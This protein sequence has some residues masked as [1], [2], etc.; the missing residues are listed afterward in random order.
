MILFINENRL[1]DLT[2][3]HA[4][5]DSKYLRPIIYLCQEQYIQPILGSVLY[6]DIRDQIEAGTVSDDYKTLLD[7]YIHIALAWYASAEM[8]LTISYKISNKGVLQGAG[9]NLIPASMTDIQKLKD[10]M[11]NKAQ[12]FGQRITDFLM[13][14]RITYDKYINTAGPMIDRIHPSDTAYQSPI[15]LGI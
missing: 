8:C 1:K 15:Y 7:D 3:I 14:N 4:N 10:D 13:E 9:E 6:R 11:L 2:L 5:A 12:F